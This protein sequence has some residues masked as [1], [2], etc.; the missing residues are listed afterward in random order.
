MPRR[1]VSYRISVA[2]ILFTTSILT[3]LLLF[4]AH[5]VRASP[6]ERTKV[7]QQQQNHTAEI[8]CQASQSVITSQQEL[9]T[10]NSPLTLSLATPT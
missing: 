1:I 8:Q 6:R 7:L 2:H 3:E 5:N 4:D 10:Y 9:D